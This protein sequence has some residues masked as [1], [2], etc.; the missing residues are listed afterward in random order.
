MRID[1]SGLCADFGDLVFR[2]RPWRVCVTGSRKWTDTEFVHRS[3]DLFVGTCGEIKA[4]AHGAARGI[5]TM[6]GDWAE[7]YD[8]AVQTYHAD[9]DR[10]GEAAGAIRNGE[11]LDDFEP[12][13]LLVFPGFTGTQDCTRK[14][15]KKRIPRVFFTVPEAAPFADLLSW[16]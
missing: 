5:D 15:R 1:M 8:I 10:Y 2:N 9:W 7:A 4:L 13:V 3:L 6:C 16:G 14:A 11:M 12:D